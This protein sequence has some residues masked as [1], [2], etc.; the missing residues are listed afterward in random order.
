MKKIIIILSDVL[1]QHA[2]YTSGA[3]YLE[4]Y[5]EIEFIIC[6][7]W[8]WNV[9]NKKLDENYFSKTQTL[10]NYSFAENYNDLITIIKKKNLNLFLI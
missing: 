8:V 10:Y 2:E 6:K 1:Y 7:S 9:Q 4:D 3:R 5:F